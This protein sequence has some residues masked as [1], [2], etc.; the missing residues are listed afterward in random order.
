MDPYLVF[1]LGT[2]T[3]RSSVRRNAGKFPVWNEKIELPY[4]QEDELHIAA[5][6]EDKIGKDDKLG[7]TSLSLHALLREHKF[8]GWVDLQDAKGVL[9]RHTA[10]RIKLHVIRE[11]ASQMRT[12]KPLSSICWM[13]RDQST[14]QGFL[15]LP[16]RSIRLLVWWPLRCSRCASSPLGTPLDRLNSTLDRPGLWSA[17]QEAS[18]SN[19]PPAPNI[20]KCPADRSSLRTKQQCN[21]SR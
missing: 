5:F 2:Q 11:P 12:G 13:L 4:H 7:E 16:V 21:L 3:F 14:T 18:L 1:R 20:S 9:T 8:D 19:D 6:D 17:R 10:G 15:H